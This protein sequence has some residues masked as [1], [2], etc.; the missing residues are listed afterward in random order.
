MFAIGTAK[1][2]KIHT[3]IGQALD[4]TG[5]WNSTQNTSPIQ[6]KNNFLQ[7]ENLQDKSVQC[8]KKGFMT[9]L[10]LAEMGC[11]AAMSP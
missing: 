8:A 5:L 1:L 11:L 2:L 4:F 6:I 7:V 9:W 10:L 3:F